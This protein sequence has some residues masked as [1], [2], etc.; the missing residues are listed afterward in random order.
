MFTITP[1]KLPS[2]FADKRYLHEYPA[3][4]FLTSLIHQYMVL[5]HDTVNLTAIGGT[6]RV[7]LQNS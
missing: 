2:V 6:L 5:Q 7:I 1:A 4:N 3:R